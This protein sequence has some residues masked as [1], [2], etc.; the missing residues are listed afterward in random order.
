MKIILCGLSG[1]GKTTIGD[2]LADRGWTHFDCEKEHQRNPDWIPHPITYMPDEEN[3]VASWGFIPHF[4]ETVWDILE[5]GYEALWLKG[6]DK[7]RVR[8]LIGRGEPENFLQNR[9]RLRQG[10]GYYAI[11]PEMVLNVFRADGSRW[12]VASLIHDV[13]WTA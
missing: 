4:M 9:T 10:L 3:V 6:N 7:Y 1:T 8:D 5:H 11:K 2:Q 12:D 13:Y